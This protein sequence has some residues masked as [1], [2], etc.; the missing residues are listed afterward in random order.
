MRCWQWSEQFVPN[1]IRLFHLLVFL[2]TRFVSKWRRKSVIHFRIPFRHRFQ[3]NKILTSH[4]NKF[5]IP[6]S[7]VTLFKGSLFWLLNMGCAL[8]LMVPPEIRP[9]PDGSD[10]FSDMRNNMA[11]SFNLAYILDITRK[12]TLLMTNLQI[13]KRNWIS[14][15]ITMHGKISNA[16]LC[17]STYL[18]LAY[19]ENFYKTGEISQYL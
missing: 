10:E 12:S 3:W 2:C 19:R 5:H 15:V 14:T 7:A 6:P 18:L 4:V 1:R 16:L 17:R 8:R 11:I 9:P 13:K